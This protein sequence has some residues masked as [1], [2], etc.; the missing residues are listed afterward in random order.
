MRKTPRCY[1]DKAPGEAL[2]G[3]VREARKDHLVEAVGLLLDCGDDGRVAVAM[4]YHPPGRDRVK[5]AVPARRLEPS[6]LAARNLYHFRLERVLREGMPDWRRIARGHDGFSTTKSARR[7]WVSK[8]ACK[9]ETS[10]GS[11]CGSRPRQR[12]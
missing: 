1:L 3:L 6:A 8:A 10:S 11:R 5:D 9:V 4:C 2:G 7:K 12:T